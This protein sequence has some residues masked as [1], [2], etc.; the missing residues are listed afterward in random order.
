MI[1]RLGGDPLQH[2]GDE[3]ALAVERQK[4]SST[5]HRGSLL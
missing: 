3:R 2:L 5:Q 1:W 4:A